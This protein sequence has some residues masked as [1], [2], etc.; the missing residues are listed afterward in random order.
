MSLLRRAA[1]ALGLA[2]LAGLALPAHAEALR[3]CDQHGEMSHEQRDRLFR[4]AALVRDELEARASA[5]RS[6][7]APA[8]TSPASASVIRT[9]A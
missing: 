7:P 2:L 6:Y 3:Y 1:F 4:F 9:P 8:S 5:S